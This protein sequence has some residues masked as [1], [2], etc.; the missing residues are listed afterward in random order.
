MT[1]K[2]PSAFIHGDV[3]EKLQ[4]INVGIMDVL[5]Q[6]KLASVV[7]IV[8][9]LY[10]FSYIIQQYRAGAVVQE[11][12]RENFRARRP[13]YEPEEV[14]PRSTKTPQ[15]RNFLDVE[16]RQHLPHHREQE[17][18]Q[19]MPQEMPQEMEQEMEQEM[20]QEM[21]QEWEEDVSY[22][23]LI[24]DPRHRQRQHHN[25]APFSIGNNQYLML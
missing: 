14:A 7:A 4:A 3:L 1:I 20:P 16:H 21:E 15:Y 8:I 10:L 2:V 12:P 23:P 18:E 24:T 5:L 25:P 19:E 11:V 22:G 13:M 6:N 17:Q 9:G